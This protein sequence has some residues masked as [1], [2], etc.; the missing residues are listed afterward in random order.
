M[1]LG[2][3]SQVYISTSALRAQGSII[4][5]GHH[6]LKHQLGW[7]ILWSGGL[8][9]CVKWYELSCAFFVCGYL[10]LM[11]AYLWL[12]LLAC[13]PC[14]RKAGSWSGLLVFVIL[15]YFPNQIVR[16]GS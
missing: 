13:A 5:Y 8:V 3:H 12:F 10:C 2:I 4:W 15:F 16:Q 1:Q 11:L 7:S 9:S 14:A 6:F